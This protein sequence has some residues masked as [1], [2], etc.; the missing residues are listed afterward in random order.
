MKEKVSDR[1]LAPSLHEALRPH[2]HPRAVRQLVVRPPAGPPR[3]LTAP[4]PMAAARRCR[5]AP[6]K[7]LPIPLR[8]LSVTPPSTDLVAFLWE[9]A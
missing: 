5:G 2:P 1:D 7:K 8:Q 6:Q 9:A 3:G 4:A